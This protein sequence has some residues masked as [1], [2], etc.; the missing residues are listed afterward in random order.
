MPRC[1]ARGRFPRRTAG[2]ALARIA[3]KA[4]EMARLISEMLETARLE[5]LGLELELEPVDLWKS[6]TWR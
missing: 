3:E 1:S 2:T 5:T 4:E 6:S